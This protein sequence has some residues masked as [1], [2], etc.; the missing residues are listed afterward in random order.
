M[1]LIA[2]P[3]LNIKRLASSTLLCNNKN[4][5]ILKIPRLDRPHDEE[6]RCHIVDSVVSMSFCIRQRSL[7]YRGEETKWTNNVE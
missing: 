5:V 6:V 7:N 4:T 3:T 2:T 1:W